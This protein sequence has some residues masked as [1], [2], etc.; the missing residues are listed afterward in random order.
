ML[1]EVVAWRRRI[2]EYC[3]GVARVCA[4]V[5]D[6]LDVCDLMFREQMRTEMHKESEKRKERDRERGGRGGG[7]ERKEENEHNYLATAPLQI[8]KKQ[9]TPI[10]IWPEKG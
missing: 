4:I 5:A 6:F 7:R 2:L 3:R 8:I 9:L 10:H 1:S